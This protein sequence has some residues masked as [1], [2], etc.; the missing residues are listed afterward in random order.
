MDIGPSRLTELI[1]ESSGA[2]SIPL[3]SARTA[4]R[5]VAGTSSSILYRAFPKSM[6]EGIT[7]VWRKTA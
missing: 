4:R 1:R 6:R 5:R 3:A 2:A 7:M